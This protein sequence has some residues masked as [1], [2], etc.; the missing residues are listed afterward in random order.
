M[1]ITV[2]IFLTVHMAETGIYNYIFLLPIVNSICLQQ[3]PQLLMVL[4]LVE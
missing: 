3:V 2:L 4:H 1:T